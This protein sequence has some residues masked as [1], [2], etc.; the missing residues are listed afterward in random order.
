VATWNTQHVRAPPLDVARHA[1][2]EALYNEYCGWA[3]AAAEFVV[4]SQALQGVAQAA[5]EF[6]ARDAD[7]SGPGSTAWVSCIAATSAQTVAMALCTGVCL[8]ARPH[9]RRRNWVAELLPSAAQTGLCLMTLIMAAR[10]GA[11]NATI[12]AALE[13]ALEVTGLMQPGLAVALALV[14]AILFFTG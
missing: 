3:L 14:D 9:V 2:R 13:A 6:V 12:V 5:G 7:G 4:A 1:W 11:P 10:R 8:F